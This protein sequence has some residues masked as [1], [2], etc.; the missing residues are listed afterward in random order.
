LPFLNCVEAVGALA[1]ADVASGDL[2]MDQVVGD[3]GAVC[4]QATDALAKSASTLGAVYK[5]VFPSGVVPSTADGFADVFCPGTS[6]MADFA[7]TLTVRGSESTLKLLMGHGIDCDYEA[8][9]SEFPRKPDGKPV[10]LKGVSGS[11]ARL[12]EVF[13][14]TMERRAAETAARLRGSK[15]EATS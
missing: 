11:A 13:M 1:S 8:A 5:V 14:A 4:T 3:L 12:A 9:L 6:T 10:S 15:S 7:R 2:S